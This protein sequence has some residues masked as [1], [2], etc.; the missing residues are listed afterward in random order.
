MMP[1]IV[2]VT[3]I[4]KCESARPGWSFDY[5][6]FAFYTIYGGRTPGLRAKMTAMNQKSRKTGI[7]K[8]NAA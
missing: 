7:P 1:I 8:V 6:A 3:P 5:E 4:R 2:N